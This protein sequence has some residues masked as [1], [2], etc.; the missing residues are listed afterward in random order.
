MSTDI[1]YNLSFNPQPLIEA[2]D[3]LRTAFNALAVSAAKL[4]STVTLHLDPR[5]PLAET[6]RRAEALAR[7][8]AWIERRHRGDTCKKAKA[9]RR[10]LRRFHT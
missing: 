9:T 2:F 3:R 6:Q 7:E 5:R 1:T 8:L 10:A 4:M